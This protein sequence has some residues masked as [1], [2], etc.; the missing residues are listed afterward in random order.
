[1]G[2]A[3]E[4]IKSYKIRDKM[5]NQITNTFTILDSAYFSS[6]TRA[7]QFFPCKTTMYP[8][9]TL[10]YLDITKVIYSNICKIYH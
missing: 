10:L 5:L 8:Q 3:I 2:F 9:S 7:T 6:A 1:M 4:I